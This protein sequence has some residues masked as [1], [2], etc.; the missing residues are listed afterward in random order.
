MYI[1][2]HGVIWL[3]CWGGEWRDDRWGLHFCKSQLCFISERFYTNGR[4]GWWFCGFDPQSSW[5]VAWI[6]HQS[7]KWKSHNLSKRFADPMGQWLREKKLKVK[8]LVTKTAS[9]THPCS[10]SDSTRGQQHPLRRQ[11]KPA[12]GGRRLRGGG[13]GRGGVGGDRAAGRKSR[14]RR[15]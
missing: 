9:E 14:R 13:G 10:T 2:C 7:K 1:L 3:A 8:W 12:D 6:S 5:N 11:H 15:R 4:H